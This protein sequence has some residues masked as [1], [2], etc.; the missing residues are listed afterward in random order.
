MWEFLSKFFDFFTAKW[1]AQFVELRGE[2]MK[3]SEQLNTLT[4]AVQ[5][6]AAQMAT[7]TQTISDKI[8]QLATQVAN[9][10][11]GPAE[12]QA[13][14]QPQIDALNTVNAALQGLASATPPP[15]D[16]PPLQVPCP[17]NTDSRPTMP[18]CAWPPGQD[19]RLRPTGRAAA[20][21][22]TSGETICARM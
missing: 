13:A 16:Q 18:W 5:Q 21:A 10:D 12:I 4:Q 11:V 9:N 20:L 3:A 8:A 2:I 15:P 1:Q 17:P 7:A 14:L 22:A 19:S 6:T